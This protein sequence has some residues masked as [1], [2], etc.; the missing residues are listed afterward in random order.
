MVSSRKSGSGDG[1]A[2]MVGVGMDGGDGHKR[3]T[4]GDN[5]FL[6]GGSEE[7]HERMTEVTIKFNEK[8]ASRGK[9]LE[10]VSRDEFVD[11]MNEASDL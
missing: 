2:M 5:F 6:A 4:K 3:V 9:R 1:R 11:L 8:L 10:D 7:T